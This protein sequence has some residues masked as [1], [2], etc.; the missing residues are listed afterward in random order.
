MGKPAGLPSVSPY[1]QN[2]GRCSRCQ[3][4]IPGYEFHKEVKLAKNGSYRHRRCGNQLRLF[5]R[6]S[7]KRHDGKPGKL[8]RELQIKRIE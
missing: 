1:D 7:G 6:V 4:N 5:P 2:G 8:R 3:I